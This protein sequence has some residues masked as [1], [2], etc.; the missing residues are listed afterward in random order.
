MSFRNLY[1]PIQIGPHTVKNR[2][3]SPPL[4]TGFAEKG[5]TTDRY[6]YY[7]AEKAKGGT[8]LIVMEASNV[9][10]MAE[11]FPLKSLEM[12]RREIVPGMRKISRAVHE[13]DAHIFCQI[14]HT[15]TQGNCADGYL[16]IVAP[17][18]LPCP[19]SR[20][21]PKELEKEEIDEIIEHFAISAQNVI[22]AGFDG[23]MLHGTHGYLITEFCSPLWNRRTDEYGGSTEN[24]M[25]FLLRIIDRV[26]E[27]IGYG[28]ALAVRLSVDDI[29]PGGITLDIGKDMVRMIENTGKVD[30]LDIDGTSYGTVHIMIAPMYADQAN[31][32]YTAAAMKQVVKKIPVGGAGRIK[33]LEVAEKILAEG[34]ADMV[35][36]ARAHLADPELANK[37]KA[38]HPE[39]IRPCIGCNQGCIG[40]LFVS[41][42]V[43]CTVNPALSRELEWGIGTLRPA[44]KKKRVLI[45]GAGP[46]GLEAAMVVAQRGHTVTVVD[47][48]TRIG[49]SLNLA[50]MLP[51][52]S[53]MDELT[54]WYEVQLK[55]LR[56]NL[57][58]G[59][60][61]SAEDILKEKVDVVVLATGATSIRNGIQG[62]TV[63]PI[64]GS[65]SKSVAVVE[66]IL[67]GAVKAGKNVV[68]LDEDGGIEPIGVAEILASEGRNV[69]IITRM[70]H[71]G[72]DLVTNLNL[73]YVYQK[74]FSSG[75][76]FS[77]NEFI[78]QI[79]PNAVTVYNV[80]TNKE[81]QIQNVDMVI[82]ATGK[83]VNNKLYRQLKGKV[84]ELY[85]IGDCVAP[86]KLD[87]A[88][89]EGHKVGR[90]I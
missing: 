78:K 59:K 4:H 62:F 22:D 26:R 63:Q 7:Y 35:G 12:F 14:V 75:V 38:G 17:S 58:L 37:G 79:T 31:L 64:P 28:S 23:V 16:P 90:T 1:T 45:V 15:G 52:R 13:Y 87:Q 25:R 69:E 72:L 32:I 46:A 40:R 55:K 44:A 3:Y 65:D 42:G 76:K 41:L 84:P 6:P 57:Q 11:N 88:I 73:A 33:S 39:D 61:L 43:T 54:R 8:G 77:P 50:A 86:R 66:D 20:I 48:Q 71:V 36:M 5:L 68:I 24:R 83:E 10:P 80:Y 34:K 47:K 51:G 29:L 9:H 30:F 18:P 70:P 82:L 27:R 21:I 60:E 2:I 53:E 19:T 74:A 81:R 85:T 56:I 89:Y 49:G 67:S